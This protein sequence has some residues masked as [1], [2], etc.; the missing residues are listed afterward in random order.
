MSR[1]FWIVGGEAT[2]ELETLK[3]VVIITEASIKDDIIEHI[4]LQGARGYT[5]DT[6]CGRGERGLRNDETL[7]GEYLR[8]IKVE[9]I[10]TKDI[11]EK[12]LSSIVERF[13]NNY[14]GIAY[15][16]DVQV[17]RAEKFKI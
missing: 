1:V 2:M 16:H 3:R 14:A 9:V 15:I 13:F 11:A 7:L 10:T 17:V 6:V 12:I 5:I 4:S 8:N